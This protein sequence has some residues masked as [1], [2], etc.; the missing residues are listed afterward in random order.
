MKK[1]SLIITLLSAVLLL[2][3]CKKDT[4][5][6]YA[7]STNTLFAIVN[8][9]TWSA[10]TINAA[11][12]YNSAAKTKVFTCTGIANN[13]KVTFSINIPSS[14]NT[15]GF[16]LNTFFADSAKMYQFAYYTKGNGD[17]V[18]QGAVGPGSGT[19]VFTAVDSVKKVATGTFSLVSRKYNYDGKGNLISITINEVADGAFNSMP[20]TFSSN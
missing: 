1:L 13:K 5:T 2:Q 7:T 10:D 16:P 3:K 17:F 15:P 20:Y 6:A 9:T 14:S 4:Y 12:T 18:E 8:D 11:I 19:V